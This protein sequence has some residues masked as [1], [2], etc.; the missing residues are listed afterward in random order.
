MGIGGRRRP[1]Y[2]EHTIRYYDEHARLFVSDTQQL[3]LNFIMEE[4]L[5]LVPAGGRILDWGCGSGRDSLA[6]MR[7]GYKVTSSDASEAMCDATSSLLGDGADVRC[8][9]FAELSESEFYDGIWACSSILHAKPNELPEVL[10]NARRALVDGGVLYCSFKRGRDMGYRHG[11]WFTDMEP[12]R[13]EGLLG[14]TPLEVIRIWET[15]DVRRGRE[16]ETWVNA[17]ARKTS[18]N[19]I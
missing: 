14:R 12:D 6:M 4:F 7:L 10:G 16:D 2:D 8:E 11:R 18:T 3:S 5:S 9:S 1:T 15:Q 13:L 17:L 19:D